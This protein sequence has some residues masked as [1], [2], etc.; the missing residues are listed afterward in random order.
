MKYADIREM[1]IENPVPLLAG[2]V[3]VQCHVF[4][5]I[6]LCLQTGR[7]GVRPMRRDRQAGAHAHEPGV[8]PIFATRVR[9]EIDLKPSVG[10]S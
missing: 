2:I 1:F 6:C 3:Q 10:A 4:E 7:R 9:P 8:E 5:T